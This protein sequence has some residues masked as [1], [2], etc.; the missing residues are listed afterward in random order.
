MQA[1]LPSGG[2]AR[3]VLSGAALLNSVA[4]GKPCTFGCGTESHFCWCHP[5]PRI[6]SPGLASLAAALQSTTARRALVLN[7]VAE[8]GETAEFSAE[9]HIHGLAQHAPE[10]TVK[11]D[12]QARRV[13]SADIVKYQYAPSDGIQVLMSFIRYLPAPISPVEHSTTW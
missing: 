8:P 10:F 1:Q 2:A 13:V 3:N 12:G 7:L 6:H 5:R 4:S 11:I 9:R